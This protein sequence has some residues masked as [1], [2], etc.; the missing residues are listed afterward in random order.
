MDFPLLNIFFQLLKK[1]INFFFQ[2]CWRKT[3]YASL[4]QWAKW[5]NLS[6]LKQGQFWP[7]RPF[8][9]FPKKQKTWYFLTP[10]TRLPAKKLGNSNAQ[11][12]KKKNAK[13]PILAKKVH[14]GSFLAKKRPFSKRPFFTHFFHF[15]IQ[16]IRK[17]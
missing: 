4:F 5:S 9:N 11:F 13:N 2:N 3:F 15:S 14:F 12:S 8:S 17:F 7:K 1:K 6:K 10:E 16:K